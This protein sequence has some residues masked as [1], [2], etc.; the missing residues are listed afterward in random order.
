M[1][2]VYVLYSRYSGAC[3]S[4]LQA[5]REAGVDNIIPI[6]IDNPAVRKSLLASALT[7][8]CVPCVVGTLDG[9]LVSYQGK[10]AFS[11]LDSM[12]LSASKDAEE[13]RDVADEPVPRGN[14]QRRMAISPDNEHQV[15]EGR[16]RAENPLDMDT[17]QVNGHVDHKLLNTKSIV[18]DMIRE[19]AS[20]DNTVFGDR[21]VVASTE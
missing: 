10:D 2:N 7:I 3:T 6:C 18:D 20:V 14:R 13:T 4:F 8:E 9:Y 19:R 16:A 15:R 17:D 11:L 21:R 12:I 5:A 1:E